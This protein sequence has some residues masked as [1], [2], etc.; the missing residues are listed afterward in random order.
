MGWVNKVRLLIMAV[1]LIPLLV[2]AANVLLNDSTPITGSGDSHFTGFSV[3]GK[4]FRFTYV[5]TNQS[6]LDKGLMGTKVTDST[7]M[8]FVF[9]SPGYYSFW[10]FGV[11]S[12]LDVIWVDASAGSNVG[13]VVSLAADSPPCHLAP[14]CTR[15]ES[16]GRANLV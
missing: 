5:A 16:T 9:S 3:N 6:M 7:T 11:N 15:Y 13:K 4:S 8:L 2:I 12:S 14:V 1:V 10:M